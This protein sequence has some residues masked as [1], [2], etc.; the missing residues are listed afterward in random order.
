MNDARQPDKPV[1]GFS[2]PII[3]RLSQAA[4]PFCDLYASVADG[5]SDK[6]CVNEITSWQR[7]YD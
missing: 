2:R 1:P 3:M 6:D 7:L 5:E 4:Q